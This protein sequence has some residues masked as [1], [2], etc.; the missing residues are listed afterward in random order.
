[1]T[2]DDSAGMRVADER[3]LP[4]I[5]AHL[6][7]AV[8]GPILDYVP[9]KTVFREA[10]MGF[11]NCSAARAEAVVDQLEAGGYLTYDADPTVRNAVPGRWI[12]QPGSAR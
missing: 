3:E 5:A 6:A 7:E 4:R 10:V 1:M 12:V 11:L 2:L 9:G 8:P